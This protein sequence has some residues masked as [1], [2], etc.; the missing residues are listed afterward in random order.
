MSGWKSR[1]D[2]QGMS[3]LE[4]IAVR[5]LHTQDNCWSIAKVLLIVFS[6]LIAY[7]ILSSNISLRDF[8]DFYNYLR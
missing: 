4:K 8:I 5:K 6:I 3:N 7:I 1:Y 2:Y